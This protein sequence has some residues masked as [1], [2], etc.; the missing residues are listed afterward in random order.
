MQTFTLPLK[1]DL[2][3]GGKKISK[4]ILINSR[5]QSFSFPV[6]SKP[7]LID[8][9]VDKILVGELKDNK[10]PESFIFQYSNAP[11]YVNRIK[12]VSYAVS[13]SKET[14]AQQLLMLALKDQD[15]VIRAMAIKGFNLKEEKVKAMVGPT[16]VN[17][18]K[19]DNNS[20]VRAV[21][22]SRL[23]MSGDKAYLPIA[24]AALK[25]RSYKV[26]GAAVQSINM[27][28]P[29]S[30]SS[31]EA[32]LDAD[33]KAHIPNDL[34]LVYAALGN[35]SYNDFYVNIINTADINKLAQVVGGYYAYLLKNT[36]PK[37]TQSGLQTIITNMDRTKLT[38]YWGK[39][40]VQNFKNAEAAKLKEAET[41]TG[42]AKD[43]LL[44]Q[45]AYFKAAAS[46]L[47]KK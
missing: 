6:A 14:A 40:F 7:D 47:D 22:L 23:A 3:V 2:Y 44:K 11:S 15:E 26:I 8:F 25:D 35:D 9:D 37:I 10:T 38:Q 16:L 30:L 13:K 29:S 24:Q 19:N 41:A 12:A 27:L 45:A 43:N 34:A 1:V 4:D 17:L 39:Q 46:D 20:N 32:G 36:N 18:A 28:E 33:T 21:A 31:V 5:E 42:E